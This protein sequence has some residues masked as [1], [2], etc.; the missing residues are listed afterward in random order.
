MSKRLGY[1]KERYRQQF[2]YTPA[3]PGTATITPSLIN[4]NQTVIFHIDSN[5]TGNTVLNYSLSNVTNSHFV[6][7]SAL[8]SGIV[9][10]DNQGN[11]N[12]S[13]TYDEGYDANNT[14]N[15]N[16]FMNVQSQGGKNL[17]N[18]NVVTAFQPV[19]F[20]AYADGFE[21][22]PPGAGWRIRPQNYSAPGVPNTDPTDP[23]PFYGTKIY[24][25]ADTYTFTGGVDNLSAIYKVIHYKLT[26]DAMS[27]SGSFGIR[28]SNS[29]LSGGSI[30]ANTLL[31]NSNGNS[32]IIWA[33]SHN[34]T[35]ANV[36]I[37][38]SGYNSFPGGQLGN[39]A[40]SV[41]DTVS[42][43]NGAT[44]TVTSIDQGFDESLA[45]KSDNT[46]NLTVTSAGEDPDNN[47]LETLIVGPGGSGGLGLAAHVNGAYYFSQGGGG[48][49][50][51]GVVSANINFTD[52]TVSANTK[53]YLGKGGSYFLADRPYR[54]EGWVGSVQPLP[55]PLNP[56]DQGSAIWVN[57]VQNVD[58]IAGRGGQGASLY[59]QNQGGQFIYPA[60][61]ASYR[62]SGGGSGGL[63]TQLGPTS[64]L[65][66]IGTAGNI[67]GNSGTA[68]FFQNPFLNGYNVTVSA[69]GGGGGAGGAGSNATVSISGAGLHGSNILAGG[70]GGAGITSNIT[71]SSVIYGAGG[72]GGGHI[73]GLGGSGNVG[74][75]GGSNTN[76]LS[77]PMGVPADGI[78]PFGSN[79]V[80]TNTAGLPGTGS[81]GGG[82]GALA[83]IAV[84][85]G[86]NLGRAPVGGLMPPYYPNSPN[87]EADMNI[88]G[89]GSSGA[90]IIRWK[91]RYKKLSL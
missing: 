11:A 42:V 56:L 8:V 83:N 84:L 53:I 41:G 54:G 73:A 78:G 43:P 60:A 64:P 16:F 81:G 22:S 13:F 27:I 69:G 6:T 37:Q 82:G 14:A 21:E 5:I 7:G 77:Y 35:D 1:F 15:V 33:T 40:F 47:Q 62:G 61:N 90:V 39:T 87:P 50:G 24:T 74:G 75:L 32:L 86:G 28:V 38:T 57:G 68:G 46:A 12:L 91:Y 30:S 20:D 51:G 88:P 65:I 34:G 19:V 3:P 45:W 55:Y 89:A 67:S 58:L 44:A 63:S 9:T 23:G 31:T 85:S 36:S 10:L 79:D 71:G 76:I 72:G 52:F 25:T 66:P 4:S 29:I 80:V 70:S 48:G 17:G 59:G 26:A 2:P 49:G 18:S